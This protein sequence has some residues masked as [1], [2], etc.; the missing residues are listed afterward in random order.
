VEISG[1]EALAVLPLALAGALG[2]AEEIRLSVDAAVGGAVPCGFGAPLLEALI[3]DTRAGVPTAWV[4]L[5]GRPPS[6]AQAAAAATRVVLRNG[7]VDVLDVAMGEALYVAAYFALSAE[8]DDRY[9]GGFCV[10]A[11]LDTGGE[12]DA[13]LGALL[14]PLR[15]SAWL[16]PGGPRFTVVATIAPVAG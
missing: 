13:A 15:P 5:E 11:D 7:L 1:R 3:K 16:V 8:A 10:V 9:E 12:P 6:P 14:D 2:V 4:R